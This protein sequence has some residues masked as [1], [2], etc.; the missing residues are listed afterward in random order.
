MKQRFSAS[1]D[2]IFSI[3]TDPKWLEQRCLALGD[4]RCSGKKAKKGRAE[5]VKLKR[6]VHRK[7]PPLV[8]RVLRPDAEFEVEERW[9]EIEEG[10]RSDMNV[11]VAGLPVTLTAIT[12]LSPKY[13]DCVV[14]IEHTCKI[15]VPLI[16]GAVEKF[17]LSQ[18]HRECVA[19]FDYLEA[20]LE[21]N[22]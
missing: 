22:C 6:T 15:H 10:Y 7:L 5:V 21:K 9:I 13:D 19:E 11:I 17:L 1:I 18:I 16:G 12:T 14:Q 4:I 8:S 2:Q 3:L 20:Y